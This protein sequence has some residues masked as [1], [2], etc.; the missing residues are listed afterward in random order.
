MPPSELAAAVPERVGSGLLQADHP[1]DADRELLNRGVAPLWV[2]PD[3]RQ[4]DRVKV[5]CEAPSQP[6]DAT[7]AGRGDPLT[8]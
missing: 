1:G 3:C 4:N 2:L 8:Q 5:S 6:L 7:F